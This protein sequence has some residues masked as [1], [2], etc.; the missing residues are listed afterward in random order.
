MKKVLTTLCAVAMLAGCTAGGSKKS[1]TST[2]SAKEETSATV[3]VGTGSVTN[4]ANKVKKVLIQL[5][6]S[7]QYL[8]QLY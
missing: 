2:S 5:H 3:M 6:S 4:V 8:R 1:S 7:I